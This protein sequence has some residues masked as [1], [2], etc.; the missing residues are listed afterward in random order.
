MIVG[1][2]ILIIFFLC[3]QHDEAA[4]AWAAELGPLHEQLSAVGKIVS[5]CQT[6]Y[7]DTCHSWI[8]VASS[9]NRDWPLSSL[10]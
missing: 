1:M 8:D 2:P 6:R 9:G 5:Q 7:T 3:I 4:Q 10:T